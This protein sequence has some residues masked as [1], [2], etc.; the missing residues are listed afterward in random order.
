MKNKVPRLY[1]DYGQYI[2]R[3]R[4][5]PLIQDGLKI[6]ERRILYSLFEIAKDH[7]VKSAKVCGHVIGNYHP[8]SDMSVAGS[9]AIMVQNAMADGQGNW[10]SNI[11]IEPCEAA[12]TRYT[13]VRSSKEVLE[14]AFEFIKYVPYEELEL[15]SEP[16]FIPTKLPFCIMGKVITQGIGFGSRTIMPTYKKNDLIK[17]LTWLLGHNKNEPI[18]KPNTDCSLLSKN[19]DFKSLLTTGT[20][21]IQYQGKVNVD[22]PNSVVVTS[23]PFNK[24]FVSVL[25]KLEKEFNSKILGWTDESDGRV[26]TKVRFTILRNRM[27]KVDVLKKKLLKLLTSSVTFE[28]NMCNVEGQVILM[29]PDQMLLT[30]YSTYKDAVKKYLVTNIKLLGDK[31]NE[32]KLL[33]KIKVVLSE[34]LRTH[35]NDPEKL[36]KLISSKTKIG[37]DIIKKLCDK[38]NITRLI[39]INTD[40]EKVEIDKQKLKD[41]LSNLDNYVWAEKFNN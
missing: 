16:V 1:K 30:A 41:D 19:V 15:D 27:M 20:G 17:R 10:G 31:I 18:I 36:F 5:F 34:C 33:K 13:E 12:A 29:S 40:I 23:I 11:G 9:L 26:G 35:P 4:S 22:G 6:V 38:Y 28:C 25:K 32:M 39:R 7:Y 21:Q 2:N 14:M 37:Y 8:H 3:Y 24:T